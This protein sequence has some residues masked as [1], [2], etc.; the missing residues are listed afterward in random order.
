MYE[1]RRQ[2]PEVR[3]L[4]VVVS[5]KTAEALAAKLRELRGWLD[6]TDADWRDICATLASGRARFPWRVGSVVS[7]RSE[8]VDAIERM[9]Q[10]LPT[11]DA[12]FTERDAA[13]TPKVDIVTADRSQWEPLLHQ[14]LAGAAVDWHGLF[15]GNG[16][17]V[18]AV[19]GYPFT[20]R[21]CW[22][23]LASNDPPR[24]AAAAARARLAR[25]VANGEAS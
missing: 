21:K 17:R 7:G 14:Y 24:G 20:R 2:P 13:A 16:F 10:N 5:A 12:N 8:L 23:S 3:C 19:P 9:M 18:A 6:R 25:P 22:I 11:T 15:R 4:P 1:T